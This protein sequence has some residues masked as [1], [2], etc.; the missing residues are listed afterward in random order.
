MFDRLI[1]TTDR[2]LIGDLVFRIEQAKDDRWELG[3]AWNTASDWFFENVNYTGNPHFTYKQ[4]LNDD[5]AHGVATALTVP[6]I[7][8]VAK[9]TS[10]SSF[11]ISAVGPQQSRDGNAGNGNRPDGHRW[12]RGQP[13]F[14]RRRIRACHLSERRGLRAGESGVADG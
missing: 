5:R 13:H 7:G 9:D 12:R 11:P 8:W 14:Q 4:F 1:W 10:S 6:M 2:A 3:D